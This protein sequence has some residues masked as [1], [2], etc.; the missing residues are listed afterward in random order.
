MGE[1]HADGGR[2]A[3][4]AAVL[5]LARA[6]GR[7]FTPGAPWPSPPRVRLRYTGA[8]PARLPP[9]PACGSLPGEW[10]FSANSARMLGGSAAP[11]PP[12]GLATSRSRAVAIPRSMGGQRH[13]SRHEYHQPEEWR[14]QDDADHG[15][16]AL[17]R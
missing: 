5:G 8:W 2:Y 3:T 9:A 4:G 6:A 14:R 13:G 11:T 15:A 12:M 17:H 16:R 7:R 10:T 1:K